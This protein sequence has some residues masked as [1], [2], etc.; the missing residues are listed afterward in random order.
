MGKKKVSRSGQA[1]FLPGI[2]QQPCLDVP[3]K[4]RDII[5]VHVA[6]QEKFPR[7]IYRKITRMVSTSRLKTKRGELSCRFVNGIH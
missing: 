5:R 7:R 6:H 3:V 4:N 2:L 1:D